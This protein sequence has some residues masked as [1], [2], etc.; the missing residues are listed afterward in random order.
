MSAPLKTQLVNTDDIILVYVGTP[1][2]II[3]DDETSQHGSK[4]PWRHLN[5]AAIGVYK[6]TVKIEVLEWDGGPEFEMTLRTGEKH[7]MDW[8]PAIPIPE[9]A[10]LLCTNMQGGSG[11][12]TAEMKIVLAGHPAHT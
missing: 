9:G 10:K 7:V 4:P 1:L 12:V 5:S 2:T 11:A 3:M 6:G 8:N